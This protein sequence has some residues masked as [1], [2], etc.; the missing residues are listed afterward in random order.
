[1]TSLKSLMALLLLTVSAVAQTNLPTPALTLTGSNVAAAW[2]I[3]VAGSPVV[4]YNPNI[5]LQS[6]DN[7]GAL[8]NTVTNPVNA[9][10]G[11]YS[12]A[13]TATAGNRFYRLSFTPVAAHP[14]PKMWVDNGTFDN[15]FTNA[16]G[17]VFFDTLPVSQPPPPTGNPP[18]YEYQDNTNYVIGTFATPLF[19]ENITLFDASQSVDPR[20]ATNGALS[21]KWEFQTSDANS[22]L[23]FTSDGITGA[24]S[25]VATVAPSGLASQPRNPND[26]RAHLWRTRLTITHLPLDPNVALTNQQKVVWFRFEYLHSERELVF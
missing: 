4:K 15:G 23:W 19:A 24:D 12:V 13:D 5:V 14:L 8:F 7:L 3:A 10:A 26:L 22:A 6:T 18:T 17:Y 9:A 16:F 1:M 21:F 20:A 11:N 2:P 25:P